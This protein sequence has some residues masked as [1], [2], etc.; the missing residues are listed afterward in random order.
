V[1]PWLPWV[2]VLAALTACTASG[3]AIAPPAEPSSALRP[4][5]SGTLEPSP[6]TSPPTPTIGPPTHDIRGPLHVV[7]TSLVDARG[8]A[9]RLISIHVPQMSRGEG[10]PNRIGR[11]PGYEPPPSVAY[12]QIAR[13]GFNSVRLSVAWANLESTPPTTGAGGKIVHHYNAAYLKALDAVVRGFTSHGVAVILD[14]HQVRWSPA[15]TN[16]RLGRGITYKCGVG[17]PKW[18]Y[19]AGGSGTEMARAER[20][21]FASPAKWTGLIDAWTFLARRYAEQRME[22]GA[23]LLNESYD[24]AVTPY[25]GVPLAPPAALHLNRFYRAVGTAIHEIDPTWLLIYEDN[26]SRSTGEMVLPQPSDLPNAVYSVHVYGTGWSDARGGGAIRRYAA[27]AAAWNV[28]MWIGE[29]T[30]FGLLD[31]KGTRSGWQPDVRTFL[32][33]CRAHDIGWTIESYENGR[34]LIRGTTTP[35]PGVVAALRAGY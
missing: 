1:P 9:V 19:P 34:F 25:P 2:A 13:W 29:F 27:R 12:S 5:V 20:T 7:G 4:S 32:A 31:R 24:L 14:M 11:C 28:P 22:I 23:E 3:A 8:H 18:L 35:R 30:L 17:M 15:F 6:P 33:Y 16:I 10:S 26:V 21:F